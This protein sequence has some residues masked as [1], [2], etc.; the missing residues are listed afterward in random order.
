MKAIQH[1]VAAFGGLLK[2]GKKEENENDTA[3]ARLEKQMAAWQRLLN[4]HL[5]G[6]EAQLR[7]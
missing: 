1:A 5:P 3:K 2:K 6:A 7:R 4:D